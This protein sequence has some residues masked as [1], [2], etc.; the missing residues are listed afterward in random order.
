MKVYTTQKGIYPKSH[1]ME[2]VHD[3]KN[4]HPKKHYVEK[5]HDTKGYTSKK[6]LHGKGT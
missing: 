3:T 1:N 2:R 5:L 6:Y 4:T